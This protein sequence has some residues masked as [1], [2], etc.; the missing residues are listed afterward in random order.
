MG[1][2]DRSLID[3]INP[4]FIT[5]TS[6]AIHHCLSAWNTGELTVPPEFGTGGV[7]QHRCDTRNI[8]HAVKNACTAPFLRLGAEFS[9]ALVVVQAKKIANAYSMIRRKIHSTGLDPAMA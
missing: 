8:D 9:S 5:L 3:K 4:T 2:K 6:T 7:A 1:M